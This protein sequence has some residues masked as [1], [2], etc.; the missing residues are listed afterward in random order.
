MKPNDYP[1]CQDYVF[2]LY[3]PDASFGKQHDKASIPKEDYIM[4]KIL[5]NPKSNAP[6]VYIPCWLIQV[7][8]NLLSHAAKILYGRLSQ[9]STEF[10]TVY[11]SSNQLA[12][13]IGTTVRSIERHIKEL[14]YVGL[15]GTFHPQAGGVNHF[16][17]Y[18][19]P[20]MR[21]SIKEQLTYKS[22][23]LDPP[24]KMAVPPDKVVGTPPSKV[25]D[26]NRKEIKEI[27]DKTTPA[28]A[29]SEKSLLLTLEDMT[30]D[31]PHNIDL[32]ML[33]EWLLTRKKKKAPLTHTAWSRTNKV[34]VKLV[35]Y[36]LNPTDCFE[37]MVANGWQGMEFRYF[38]K[39][40]DLKKHN[41]TKERQYEIEK[42]KQVREEVIAYREIKKQ[43]V[44][45][46]E[47]PNGLKKLK[48][49]IGLR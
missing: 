12:E 13:E 31:N 46:G 20:W 27:K 30:K 4:Q 43:M 40:M 49:S 16:E 41:E 9:W 44:V 7:S 23:P 22:S 19:H 10:G 25:A 6:S 17:F 39:D 14:K 29:V 1:L 38:E 45:R 36:G 3:K 5:H 2:I 21:E 26:I 35:D 11:R 8:S 32:Q 18:D 34:M 33:N 24:S 37:K 48:E 42:T 47:I 15:I 28:I